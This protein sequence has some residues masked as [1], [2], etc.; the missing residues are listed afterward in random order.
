MLMVNNVVCILLHWVIRSIEDRMHKQKDGILQGK[1]VFNYSYINQ[2]LLA[3][4][5]LVNF[6][7]ISFAQYSVI[8]RYDPQSPYYNPKG[9]H[10]YFVVWLV[11]QL[12]MFY[13]NVFSQMMFL[14]FSR[15]V[16]FYTIR[17]R[18][19]FGGDKRYVIDF[20]DF[21]K[22]DFHWFSIYVIQTC[23]AVYA[24]FF[25]INA[26][27]IDIGFSLTVFIIQ[28]LMELF[29]L[30]YVFFQKR[31]LHKIV[32]YFCIFTSVVCSL[33]ILVAFLWLAEKKSL[34][35]SVYLIEHVSVHYFAYM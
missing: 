28:N 9:S 19:G 29:L 17:E 12:L 2:M 7:S 10:S 3:T 13:F 34:F 11:Y 22:D 5:F 20:L 23:L 26:S 32:I 30:L 1:R 8:N 33:I 24:Y 27:T 21:C 14:S 18:A 16:S 31:E 6:F 4:K 15:I 35:W 25:R